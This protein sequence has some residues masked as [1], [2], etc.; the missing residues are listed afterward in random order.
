[1][2]QAS[3]GHTLLSQANQALHL[4]AAGM[5]ELTSSPPAQPLAPGAR[6]HHRHRSGSKDSLGFQSLGLTDLTTDDVTEVKASA[7]IGHSVSPLPPNST[8]KTSN[9]P[10]APSDH[11]GNS[12][13]PQPRSRSAN[14]IAERPLLT[15]YKPPAQHAQSTRNPGHKAAAAKLQHPLPPPP[16]PSPPTDFQALRQNMRARTQVPWPQK[17]QAA[18]GWDGL[19]RPSQFQ[20]LQQPLQLQQE[21]Q[22]Q[23]EQQYLTASFHASPGSRLTGYQPEEAMQFG[24]G[25]AA[26][27]IS[28]SNQEGVAPVDQ[29]LDKLRSL[30]GSRGSGVEAQY[31]SRSS[32]AG[33]DSTKEECEGHGSPGALGSKG[34]SNLLPKPFSGGHSSS[35]GSRH[36]GPKILDHKLRPLRMA[37]PAPP[38]LVLS[39]GLADSYKMITQVNEARQVKHRIISAEKQ[40]TPL[41]LKRLQRNGIS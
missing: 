37:N 7:S 41:A 4:P 28:W 22:E 16:P 32:P 15:V 31:E 36:V 13:A 25:A 35:S 30:A 29:Q 5:P 19:T 10:S 20:Q 21:Q 40:L 14:K 26:K 24:H 12:F 38:L 2:P 39:S 18:Q 6:H 8:S 27:S 9:T 17:A 1:V 3:R 11:D 23:Q 33:G 34:S